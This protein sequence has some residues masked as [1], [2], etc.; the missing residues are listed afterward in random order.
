MQINT[1]YFGQIEIK[2]ENILTFP[3]G[4]PA[5]EDLRK[6]IL[7]VL[8][9]NNAFTCLQSIGNEEIA[10]LMINP[11]DFFPEYDVK[12]PDEELEEID[13]TKEEQVKVYNIVTIPKDPQ[14]I[15]INLVGP[16]IINRDTNQAKQIILTTSSY[17]TKHPILPERKG[18]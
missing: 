7:L 8:P 2:E 16:I 9:D 1:K 15:T 18:V 10:F 3:K 5:F 17:H 14:N 12:I 4:L 6:F 13:I 11:W